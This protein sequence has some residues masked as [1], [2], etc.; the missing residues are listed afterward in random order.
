[1]LRYDNIGD[2]MKKYF[3][4][5]LVSL[6]IGFFLSYF[7]LTQYKDFKGITVST[8]GDEYYFLSNGEYSSKE[9]MEQSGVN[10]ENYV[11]RKD[12][13][14]YYMYVGITKNKD[15]AEKMKNYYA[16]KNINVEIKD[17]YISSNKFKE[18]IDNLDNILINSNDEI[19]ITEIINQG[20]NKY[21]EIILNGS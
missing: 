20:L 16:S 7:F 10:L 17:F 18:A 19:V 6:I 15:N 13:V 1:M 9:E 4:A 3:K 14:N 21:E 2:N 8:E 5:I 11:Y 12:G